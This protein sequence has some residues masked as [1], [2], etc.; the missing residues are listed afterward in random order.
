MKNSKGTRRIS[1][2]RVL[3]SLLCITLALV[4]TVMIAGTTYVHSL[5]SAFTVGGDDSINA[6]LS[7]EDLATATD[8]DYDPNFTGPSTEY[9]P[10]ET[11]PNVQQNKD[12]VNILLIGEDRKG[13]SVRQRSDSMILCSFN[14]KTNSLTMVSFLRDIYISQIPGFWADKLN[15]AYQYGGPYTLKRT[16]AAYFGVHVDACVMVQ[17]EGFIGLIDMLGGV[18]IELTK[19][20]AD[21]MNNNNQLGWEMKP[22]MSHLDGKQALFYSRIR[23]I[24]MDAKRAERQRKV[25]TALINAYKDK[26]LPEMITLAQ[27]IVDIGFVRTDMKDVSEIMYYVRTLFPMLADIN[28]KNQQIPIEGSYQN[29][30]VGNVVDAKVCDLDINRKILQEILG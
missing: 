16:L 5:L 25:L 24:D 6:T 17:F 26:P 28:I 4:L 22:G 15:A 10:Q 18:D 11:L 9:V 1:W 12:I 8:P 2:Q 29:M 21:Y 27:D 19:K 30:K 13:E 23:M 20:E 14:T 3:L 7:P